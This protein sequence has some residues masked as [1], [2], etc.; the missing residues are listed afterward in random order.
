MRLKV[1][2][3]TPLAIERTLLRW[4]RSTV[5]LASLSSYLV[6]AA[7]PTMQLNGLLLGL[8]AI[9]FVALPAHSYWSRSVELAN[10]KSEQPKVDRFLPTA[11]AWSFS[12]ILLATLV[13]SIT[14]D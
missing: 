4:M 6:S 3:K 8:V 14:S 5:L 1:D 11:M 7:N 12:I 13:V 10:P 2:C 9:L